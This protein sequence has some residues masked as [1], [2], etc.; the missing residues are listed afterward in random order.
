MKSP[1]SLTA[2]VHVKFNYEELRSEP[3]GKSEIEILAGLLD[4]ASEL[5]PALQELLV[6]FA[7]YIKK[8]S[9]KTGAGQS[10]G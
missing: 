2:L 6:K 4:H 5:D 9:E 7:D 8:T 1:K 10:P 3:L